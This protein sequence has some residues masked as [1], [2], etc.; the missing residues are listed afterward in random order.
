MVTMSK[1]LLTC[2]YIYNLILDDLICLVLWT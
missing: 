2:D 1:A